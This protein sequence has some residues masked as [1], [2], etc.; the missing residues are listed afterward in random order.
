M[1]R[2]SRRLLGPGR[3]ADGRGETKG[4]D[5]IMT[6]RDGRTEGSSRVAADQSNPIERR[7]IVQDGGGDHLRPGSDGSGLFSRRYRAASRAELLP[8]TLAAAKG[9]GKLPILFDPIFYL[10]SNEDVRSSGLDPLEHYLGWGAT[11]GR[12]PIGDVDPRELH[13][14][15]RDLHRL[16]PTDPTMVSFDYRIYRTLNP[17]LVSLD[18]AALA[19]H[20]DRHGRTEQ[21]IYSMYT[22]VNRVCDNPREIPLDF[23]PEE[24]AGLHHEPEIF[25]DRPLEALSHYMRH[26]R[27][28]SKCY[29]SRASRTTCAMEESALEWHLHF[30]DDRSAA[31]DSEKNSRTSN[32]LPGLASGD[33]VSVF[34]NRQGNFFFA[35]IQDLLCSA[36]QRIGV[37]AHAAFETEVSDKTEGLKIVVA[38]HEFFYLGAMEKTENHRYFGDAILVNTEQMGTQ[39]FSQAFRHLSSAKWI[40]D[41]NLQSAATLTR[42]GH[43]ASFLPLGYLP[44]YEPLD[45][46]QAVPPT[47]ATLSA[48]APVFNAIPD[49]E[50]ALDGRPIDVL[51]IGGLTP[52]RERFFAQHADFFS[53]RRCFIHLADIAAPL[54]P[55]ACHAIGPEAFTGL[56]QRARVLLNVH[57]GDTP[58]FEW[59]RMVFYGFWQKTCVVTERASYV[60]GFEPGTHY[61]EDDLAHLPGL[62]EWATRD[63]QGQDAAASATEKAFDCLRSKYRMT[64][65]LRDLFRMDA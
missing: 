14:L 19:E 5:R 27:W 25:K 15:V 50:G 28:E 13:P 12:M 39:W 33:R 37:A 16:D 24:Y 3:E 60:P 64:D 11:E 30:I 42:I 4:L 36:L 57:H 9:E 8:F 26:G 17:D 22:F 20:Y 21:R 29:S 45:K 47:P 51:F 58:Y 40:L 31:I 43:P 44:G 46:P 10:E 52:R 7:N 23:N 48:Q 1:N 55:E 35:Q 18:D 6:E 56:S 49:P 62:I 54:L 59:Q 65:I 38:P 61:F 2:R 63:P 32:P 41:V 34:C 53:Q